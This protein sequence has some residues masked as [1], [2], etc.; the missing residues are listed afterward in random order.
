MADKEK[1]DDEAKDAKD[2]QLVTDKGTFILGSVIG[3]GGF[4]TVYQG[5]SISGS[6]VAIKQIGLAFLPKDQLSSIMARK[7]SGSP[8][9]RTGG[10]GNAEIELLRSLEHENIVRY[11][12]YAKTKETLSIIM[13]YVENGSLL[14]IMKRFG[15]FPEPLVAIYIAQVLEGLNYLHEQGVVHRDIKGANI[16]VTKEGNIKIADFGIASQ[17]DDAIDV[18][19]TPY[20][21]APEIIELSGASTK[22]DIWSVG[23]TVIELLTGQPPYFQL[24]PMPALF[25]IVQDECPPFPEGITA[26]CRDWLSWA[27]KKDPNQRH[28]ARKLL[29]HKW[30][31]DNVPAKRSRVGLAD[32]QKM[33]EEHRKRSTALPLPPLAPA[34]KIVKTSEPLLASLSSPRKPPTPEEEVN[35]DWDMEFDVPSELDLKFAPQ[36]AKDKDP[37]DHAAP[38]P[39]SPHAAGLRRC[40]EAALKVPASLGHLRDGTRS[41]SVSMRAKKTPMMGGGSAPAERKTPSPS[42]PPERRPSPLA[43]QLALSLQVPPPS[44]PKLAAS[45]GGDK[46]AGGGDDDWGDSFLSEG[47]PK[48]RHSPSAAAGTGGRRNSLVRGSVEGS[49]LARE[50]VPKKN[51]KRSSGMF[52]TVG[53]LSDLVKGT[54]SLTRRGAMKIRLL[55]S[56]EE[57]SGIGDEPPRAAAQGDSASTGEESEWPEFDLTGI[58][59]KKD[60]GG[61][62]Q[63]KMPQARQ[64]SEGLDDDIFTDDLDD[65]FGDMEEEEE[66]DFEKRMQREEFSKVLSDVSQLIERIVPA[67]PSSD[68]IE[69]CRKL[70]PIFEQYAGDKTR[71][72]KQQGIVAYLDLLA[73]TDDAPALCAVLDLVTEVLDEDAEIQVSFG[74]VGGIPAVLALCERP[75]LG[76]RVRAARCLTRLCASEFSLQML[77]G[78]CGLPSLVRVLGLP[79]TPAMDVAS[80]LVGVAASVLEL[81]ANKTSELSWLVAKAGAVPA[82]LRVLESA[83]AGSGAELALKAASTIVSLASS[84][85]QTRR[86]MCTP[87]LLAGVDRL[88]QA[89]ASG[90]AVQTALLKTLRQLCGEPA[91]LAAL[92][93]SGALRVLVRELGREGIDAQAQVHILNALANLCRLDQERQLE[94]AQQGAVPL[95]KKCGAVAALREN[96]FTMLFDMLRVRRAREHMWG[97]DMLQFFLD[98]LRDRIYMPNALDCISWWL[99]DEPEEV[100][101]ILRHGKNIHSM[102][103]SFIKADSANFPRMTEPFAKIASASKGLSRKFAN[104]SELVQALLSRLVSSST[105]PDTKKDLLRLLQALYKNCR[106]KQAFVTRWELVSKLAQ[107]RKDNHGA[108]I[109]VAL[110]D[111]TLSLLK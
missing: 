48:I 23:C 98:L 79:D 84:T 87:E 47:D 38:S 16:L 60:D 100:K 49:P 24:A 51:A 64:R 34:V 105:K 81:S 42:P 19:G 20:W 9:C 45:E 92:H 78:S 68:I 41:R 104:N 31:K 29:N 90:S 44:K 25:R 33:V 13:E 14:G 109:L 26:M 40:P 5:L 66:D 80:G 111:E 71:I 53:E 63:L 57:T 70:V 106:D 89:S 7:P 74:I 86:L 56:L 76:V 102:T 28:S 77:V 36:M 73:V 88:L 62:L 54:A 75:D 61:L 43:S 15:K 10:S 83:A 96:S 1:P 30:I 18:T 110:V 107:I 4:G 17:R 6:F 59:G 101:N 39:G 93:S 35:D 85:P 50:V 12:T 11:I 67:A 72:V 21:M 94:A 103:R 52:G 32:Q 3:K 58:S 97:N 91:L 2:K 95:L 82:L 46:A 27:L 69:S 99:G 65:P 37:K 8:K 55:A 108:R 22:S